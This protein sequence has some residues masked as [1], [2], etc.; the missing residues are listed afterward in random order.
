MGE[1]RTLL[2]RCVHREHDVFAEQMIEHLCTDQGC[3]MVNNP[4]TLRQ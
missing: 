2:V 1:R 4:N 3:A